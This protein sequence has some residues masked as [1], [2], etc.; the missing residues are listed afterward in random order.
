LLF[1]CLI[2]SGP[3][4]KIPP[5]KTQFI[6]HKTKFHYTKLNSRYTKLNSHTTQNSIPLHKTKFHYTK[7]NIWKF[8]Q[9]WRDYT[10]NVDGDGYQC[11]QTLT[12]LQYIQKAQSQKKS[13]TCNKFEFNKF[14][15]KQLDIYLSI[16]RATGGRNM[17]QMSQLKVKILQ[18]RSNQ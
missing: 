11:I 17:T 13:A 5:H 1:W 10:K 3:Q 2:Y 9:H 12:C 7:L 8:V 16:T 4:N 14:V 6:L 18:E 15:T